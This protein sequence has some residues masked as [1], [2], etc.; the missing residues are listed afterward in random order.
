VSAA[1]SR[2][3]DEGLSPCEGGSPGRRRR[4]R[5]GEGGRGVVAARRRRTNAL[6]V[7]TSSEPPGAKKETK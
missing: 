4:G 6:V 3:R 2:A 7:P 1:G 5:L